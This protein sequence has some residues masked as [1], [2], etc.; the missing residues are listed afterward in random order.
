MSGSQYTHDMNLEA[1]PAVATL[2]PGVV[3]HVTNER[4][5]R[6]SHLAGSLRGQDAS[7]FID[8]R[9]W[10]GWLEPGVNPFGTSGCERRIARDGWGIDYMH[11]PVSDIVYATPRFTAESLARC[12]Q[13]AAASITAEYRGFDLGAWR[14]SRDRSRIVSGLKVRLV[15]E[16]VPPASRVLDVG[17]NVGL[18]VLLCQEVGFECHG[19]DIAEPAIGIGTELL[20]IS[21][22]SAGTIDQH[23]FEPRSF[24]AIVIWDVLEH[25]PA[26]IDVTRQC[27]A[28][29]KPGGVLFAQVPNHRGIGAR[30]KTL[31]CRLHLTQGRYAHFGF[32]WHLF[33]FSP[34][35][36]RLALSQAGLDTVRIASFSHR[37]KDGMRR[38]PMARL[39]ELTAMSDYLYVVG[40]KGRDR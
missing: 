7:P 40:R 24:D 6:T 34:R 38:G 2:T 36:L 10:T 3:R 31:A 11:D 32:P 35:S 5:P 27:A 12:Y 16:F 9:G 4:P 8:Y 25:L 20:G 18:F 33:H 29:L 17:C 15:Q 1:R 13:D 28:L 39:M 37:S 14:V 22:L 23:G 30:L 21:R 19:L 26:P